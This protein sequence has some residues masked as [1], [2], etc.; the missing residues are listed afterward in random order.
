MLA[1]LYTSVLLGIQIMVTIV[2]EGPFEQILL[3]LLGHLW[4]YVSDY[5]I[6]LNFDLMIWS[7][8][9]NE[10]GIW[11]WKKVKR[12]IKRGISEKEIKNAGH[13][14]HLDVA[15]SYIKLDNSFV[16]WFNKNINKKEHVKVL[17]CLCFLM[18]FCWMNVNCF[19]EF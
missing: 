8:K 10:I 17:I 5:W 19:I 13:C 3:A 15:F 9:C 18:P 6:F 16:N 14:M 2:Y 11:F 7:L 1:L 12:N 4:D